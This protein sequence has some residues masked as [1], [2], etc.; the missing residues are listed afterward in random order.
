MEGGVVHP[1][2]PAPVTRT[3]LQKPWGWGTG[4]TFLR[5]WLFSQKIWG[6]LEG[7]LK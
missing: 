1:V 3:A 4:N 2:F 5:I 7:L 6:Y